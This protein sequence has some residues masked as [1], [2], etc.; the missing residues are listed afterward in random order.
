[1][2]AVSDIGGWTEEGNQ[3]EQIFKKPINDIFP[4]APEFWL[5]VPAHHRRRSAF[6]TRLRVAA[7]GRAETAAAPVTTRRPGY[8]STSSPTD[9]QFRN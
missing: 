8:H 4:H 5:K 2:Y 6:M 1:M 9:R 7:A 3:M